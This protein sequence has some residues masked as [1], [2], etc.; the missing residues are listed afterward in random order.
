M[1][2]IVNDNISYDFS[3]QDEIVS[4]KLE[5]R[6]I[7]AKSLRTSD[8]KY[9][10]L[11]KG[12]M[13]EAQEVIAK[14]ETYLFKANKNLN[15]EHLN[16]IS[17]NENLDNIEVVYSDEFG[18]KYYANGELI[19]ITNEEVSNE[20][21][22]KFCKC[23]YIKDSTI[24][25]FYLLKYENEN[26]ARDYFH[27]I[28]KK[29]YKWLRF[30]EPNFS[31]EEKMKFPNEEFEENIG[32]QEVFETQEAYKMIGIDILHDNSIY[33]NPDIKIAVFDIG[34]D[35]QH[36]NLKNAFKPELI[37]HDLIEPDEIPF[38]NENDS[39][40]TLCAGLIG[41]RKYDKK[42]I[43]GVARGCQLLDYRIGYLKSGK[44]RT[45]IFKIIKAFYIATFT[46]KAHIIN[47]SWGIKKPF[48]TLATMIKECTKNKKN[49]NGVIVVCSA[50]NDSSLVHF[51]AM[52]NEVIAVSA[53]D[54]FKRPKKAWT[55]E[56]WGSNY[57][58]VTNK[59]I[60]V[61]APG[62]GILSTDLTGERGSDSS[63]YYSKFNGTSSAAPLVSGAIGIFLSIKRDLNTQV[64][65]EVLNQGCEPFKG[66]YRK[67]GPGI[68]HI[69]N[70]IREIN[71]IL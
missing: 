36:K 3:Y 52:M 35:K 25:F 65:K 5:E 46:H 28:K 55:A 14:D 67:Y 39:H 12:L 11:D 49:Q 34:I 10:E 44:L 51:P 16:I 70:T 19:V 68:L 1:N 30:I 60:D 47:C 61:A 22:M 13:L 37:G 23:E 29:G 48:N 4:I 71:S 32:G 20:D 15:S 6:H 38:P 7:K 56:Q 58:N 31:T 27:E 63:D 42:G 24:D 45:S 57:G 21:I 43:D 62:T 59:K 8:K 66:E 69:E 40:G 26:E 18:K 53:V 54:K 41:A 9:I 64:L 33:C 17:R 50:G 2:Y